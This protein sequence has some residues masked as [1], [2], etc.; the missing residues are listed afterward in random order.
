MDEWYFIAERKIR[1]AMDGGAFDHLEG[2]GKPLDLSVNPFEDPAERMANRLLKNNGFA[3]AW[4]EEAK[5]IEGEARRLRAQ[6][7][8]S[9]EDLEKRVMQLNRRIFAFNLKAPATSLHK[10]LVEIDSYLS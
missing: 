9:A 6:N 5:E 10:R 8:T 1:E 3:S 7:A 4:I 2:A